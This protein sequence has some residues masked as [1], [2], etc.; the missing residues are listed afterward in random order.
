MKRKLKLRKWV[1][2]G[3][4]YIVV[5]VILVFIVSVYTN[6]IKQINNGTLKIISQS[7]M[8]ERN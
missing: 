5:C 1:K 4:S 8:A 3:I 7:E 6:K 2:E